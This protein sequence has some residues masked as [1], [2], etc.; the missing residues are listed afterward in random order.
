MKKNGTLKYLGYFYLVVSILSLLTIF[1]L[2][3]I[4]DVKIFSRVVSR[5][6]SFCIQIFFTV[7]VFF[8]YLQIRQRRIIALYSACLY[9]IF[10]IA[11]SL[12][13]LVSV[14]SKKGN[15]FPVIQITGHQSLGPLQQIQASI[16]TM[17][18]VHAANIILGI[19]IMFLLFS[20]KESFK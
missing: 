16:V 20:K 1:L 15:I 12:L 19:L 8:L 14:F 6:V 7:I 3:D 9:H 4:L 5:P 10:F 13:G 11:N 18:A 2:F 17:A